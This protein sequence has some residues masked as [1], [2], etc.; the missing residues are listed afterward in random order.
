MAQE[1]NF[2]NRIKRFLDE[3]GVWYVKFFA[4][5]FTKR[6]IPDLLCC[7]NGHFVAIEVKAERG[8]LSELQEI[9]LQQ[10]HEAGGTAM[11]VKP[12]EFDQ[13]KEFIVELKSKAVK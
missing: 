13:F 1:K 3:Q 9:Q 10:I 6:G 11:V 4:N 2:E 5:G 8:E 7:V 12:N